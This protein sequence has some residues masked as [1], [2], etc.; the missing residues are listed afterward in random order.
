MTIKKIHIVTPL[1]TVDP[2]GNQIVNEQFVEKISGEGVYK[3]PEKSPLE[4]FTEL[5][6][7]LPLSDRIKFQPLRIAILQ[8]IADDDKEAALAM[9]SSVTPENEPQ[10]ILINTAKSMI[11][12]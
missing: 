4:Q 11:G 2:L 6:K 12:G 7:S 9:L 8:S 10:Q 5:Y 1:G 3:A